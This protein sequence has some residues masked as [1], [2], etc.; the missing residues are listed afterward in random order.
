MSLGG[1]LSAVTTPISTLGES[2]A[3]CPVTGHVLTG[4]GCFLG[5][6]VVTPTFHPC[7]ASAQYVD[8][9]LGRRGRH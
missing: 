5:P 9:R 2:P 6:G 7:S 3:L 4:N 1:E 8:T